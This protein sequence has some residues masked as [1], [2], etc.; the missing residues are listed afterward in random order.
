M[1]AFKECPLNLPRLVEAV[2]DDSTDACV[3]HHSYHTRT[4]VLGR[5]LTELSYNSRSERTRDP[6]PDHQVSWAPTLA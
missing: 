1:I 3:A 4:Y 5:G 2:R 6:F